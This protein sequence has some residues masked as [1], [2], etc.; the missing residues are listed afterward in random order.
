MP[1]R[2]AEL[3]P[4]VAREV[5]PGSRRYRAVNEPVEP[6]SPREAPQFD[7]SLCGRTIGRKRAV[8]LLKDRRVVCVGC[9]D[10]GNLYDDVTCIGSRAAIASELEIWP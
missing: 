2:A 1:G 7:C 5:P 4:W 10:R 6:H 3:M 8:G 9:V